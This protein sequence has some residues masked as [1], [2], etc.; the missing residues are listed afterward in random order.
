MNEINVGTG[1]TATNQDRKPFEPLPEGEYVVTADRFTV[2][3]AKSG[4]D[5]LSVSFK[6][7]EGE[8]K[9]RLLWAN[10]SVNHP[11]VADRAI[12]E[13]EQLVNCCGRKL[14]S[15]GGELDDQLQNISSLSGKE[16]LVDVT[17][18]EQN[19][20]Y[21]AKNEIKAFKVD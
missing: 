20:P 16:L 7:K 19:P 13:L 9:G 8:N 12:K 3:R 18:K 14:S 6:V 15:L 4:L 2:K 1:I 21:K 17:I 11:K 10:F 5:Y